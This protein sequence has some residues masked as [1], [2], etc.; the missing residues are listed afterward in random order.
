MNMFSLGICSSLLMYMITIKK[1]TNIEERLKDLRNSISPLDLNEC[2]SAGCITTLKLQKSCI[3]TNWHR[4]R[5][6][7]HP[8]R[9]HTAV[10]TNHL[11]SSLHRSKQFLAD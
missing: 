6:H 1:S 8:N 2:R 11:H 7:A 10:V 5:R 9:S 4:E 3:P